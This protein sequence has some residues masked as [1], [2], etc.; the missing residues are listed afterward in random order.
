MGKRKG[1]LRTFY[2]H[3]ALWG[4]EG[5]TERCLQKQDV[6]R[7]CSVVMNPPWAAAPPLSPSSPSGMGGSSILALA[8]KLSDLMEHKSIFHFLITKLCH[9]GYWR[10]AGLRVLSDAIGLPMVMENETP[11]VAVWDSR[12]HCCKDSGGALLS[13]QGGVEIC[14]L[15]QPETH[16]CAECFLLNGE[17]SSTQHEPCNILLFC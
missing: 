14:C 1:C 16:L 13:Q 9:K 17:K 3:S 4:F 11:S 10:I 5:H 6:R 15:L 2:N 12:W 8:I 7:S